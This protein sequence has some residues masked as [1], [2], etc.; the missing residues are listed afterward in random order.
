MTT[1]NTDSGEPQPITPDL[2]EAVLALNNAHAVEL[3]WLAPSQLVSLLERAFYARTI[4]APGIE[5]PGIGALGI[6][7]PEMGQVAAFL[8]AFDEAADYD[9]PNYLWFRDRYERFVYIDRVVVAPDARGQG[10]A[11]KL[12]ADLIARASALG[13]DR[14]VCEVNAD[15]PNPASDSFHARHG[16]VPVGSATIHGGAKTVRYLMLPLRD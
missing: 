7:A 3:S 6:G 1:A 16:F 2:R 14:L 15:P 5:A 12:Y 13:Y 8:L 4:G 10:V 11:D 9:S